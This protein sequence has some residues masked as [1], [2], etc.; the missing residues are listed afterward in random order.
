MSSGKDVSSDD[1]RGSKRTWDGNSKGLEEFDKRVGRWCRKRH[2]TEIAGQIATEG[3]VGCLRKAAV[4]SR[5][6]RKTKEQRTFERNEQIHSLYFV[7][8]LAPRL[9]LTE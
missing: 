9:F 5:L 4:N 8:D 2:G 1:E 6:G 7:T 3:G